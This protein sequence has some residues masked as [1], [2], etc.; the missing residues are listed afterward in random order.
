MLRNESRQTT[1]PEGALSKIAT[2]TMQHRV[3][4]IA[5]KHN[6]CGAVRWFIKRCLEEALHAAADN[7]GGAEAEAA[8][9][10]LDAYYKQVCAL[11]PNPA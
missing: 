7:A 3:V 11:N 4:H 10:P 5:V 1:C 6:N 8:V 9:R 2:W